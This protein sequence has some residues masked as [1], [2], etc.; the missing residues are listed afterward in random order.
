PNPRILI[1]FYCQTCQQFGLPA[2]LWPGQS[3]APHAVQCNFPGLLSLPRKSYS[4][5]SARCHY[6]R[7]TVPAVH[8]LSAITAA[9]VLRWWV[10]VAITAA[11]GP[12][13]FAMCPDCQLGNWAL[14]HRQTPL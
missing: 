3:A 8:V 12:E 11:P 7:L 1:D 10:A 9:P 5:F 6:H 14:C 13:F 4:K 2:I